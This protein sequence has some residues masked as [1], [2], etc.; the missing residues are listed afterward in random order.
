MAY[1]DQQF[2]TSSKKNYY[3]TALYFPS[4]VLDPGRPLFRCQKFLFDVGV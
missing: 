3:T 2:N 4:K 1:E